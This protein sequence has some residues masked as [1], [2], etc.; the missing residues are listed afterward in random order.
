MSAEVLIDGAAF[1]D[2]AGFYDEVERKL[3]KG[4][5]WNIGRNLDALNDVLRGGFGVH[6]YEAPV[7]ITWLHSDKSKKDLGQH[8]TIAYV[9]G[10]LERCHP[11]N[12][13][14]VQQ[15]LK[16]A[17]AGK[18]EMLFDIIVSIIGGHEHVSLVL[19]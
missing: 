5:D 17:K 4:L 6:E 2:L 10:K 13:K 7:H 9:R 11:S 14:L 12:R 1:D 18:G 16:D 3:T 8:A 19:K 15:E